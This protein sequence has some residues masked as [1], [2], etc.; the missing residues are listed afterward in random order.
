VPSAFDTRF[1]FRISSLPEIRRDRFN[2]EVRAFRERAPSG[3]IF[4]ERLA[5]LGHGLTLGFM[6][7]IVGG[8]SA[9]IATPFGHRPSE[10]FSSVR[11]NFLADLERGKQDRPAESLV[12]EVGPGLFSG[13]GFLKGFGF[14]RGGAAGGGLFGL[15]TG[16]SLQDRLIRGGTGA[17]L[18][19]GSGLVLSRLFNSAGSLGKTATQA[20]RSDTGVT[21]GGLDNDEFMQAQRISRETGADFVGHPVANN[22]G[23]DGFLAGQRVSLKRVNT[24]DVN[25]VL[26]QLQR[27]E[28][29]ASRAGVTGIHVDL[30]ATKL[31][32]RQIREHRHFSRPNGIFSFPR[33]GNGIEQITIRA[34]DGDIVLN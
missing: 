33:P 27:A 1:D 7:E 20:P 6:D 26:T 34:L 30:E 19:A 2:S 4:Q 24:T 31:T 29:S 11:N 3:R 9:V 5:S 23:F 14:V 13:F 21:R 16:E 15:G 8:L 18:G 32:V 10:T 22:P 25:G 17:L 12:L 28:S